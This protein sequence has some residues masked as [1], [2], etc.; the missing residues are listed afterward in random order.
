MKAERCKICKIKNCTHEKGL[1]YC[2]ECLD[3]PCKQIKNLENSY[4]KRYNIG[5]I[6]NSNKVHK[7]GICLFL[8]NEQ[9]KWICQ[10]C[11]GLILLND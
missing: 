10:N 7:D 11:S 5:L 4:S 1:I 9:E 2:Y 3:F 8:T 6:E